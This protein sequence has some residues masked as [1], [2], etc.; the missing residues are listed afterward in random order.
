[1]AIWVISTIWLFLIM[2]LG[3]SAPIFPLPHICVLVLG[4]SQGVGGSYLEVESLGSLGNSTLHFLRNC[5]K[6]FPSSYNIL[7]P[8][9]KCAGLQFLHVITEHILGFV[10]VFT[11]SCPSGCEASL[12]VRLMADDSDCLLH[13]SWL[14]GC[15]GFLFVCFVSFCL[16]WGVGGSLH[17]VALAILEFTM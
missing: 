17:Y 13:S 6:V 11:S 9:H 15:L 12:L 2:L 1:M 5:Q 10:I 14:V 8:S 16:T 4:Y 3:M 7:Y